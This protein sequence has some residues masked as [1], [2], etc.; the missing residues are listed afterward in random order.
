MGGRLVCSGP[1]AAVGFP[2]YE[3]YIGMDKNDATAELVLSNIE[4][5]E[6]ECGSPHAG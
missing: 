5:P 3:D 6:F 2:F 1:D 4:L